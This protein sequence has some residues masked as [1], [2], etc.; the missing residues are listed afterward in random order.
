MGVI[1]VRK[2]LRTILWVAASLAVLAALG[3][4]G[5]YQAWR[6]EP[7]FYTKAL[8]A[9]PQEYEKAGDELEKN[10]LEL[11]N[12]VRREGRWEVEFSDEQ[13]NGWLAVDLQKNFSDLLPKTIQDPRVA[14]SQSEILIACRF[15]DGK[16]KTI[17]SLGVDVR[18][19]DEPNVVAVRFRRARAG[20]IPL[21]LS[22]VI[23]KITDAAR[24]SDVALRWAQEQGDPVAL[25]EVP[26]THEA[27]DSKELL[28][29]TI[30]LD[31]G[32]VRIAGRSG[33]DVAVRFFAGSSLADHF[34]PSELRPTKLADHAAAD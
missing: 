3:A 4:A 16:A 2:I 15:D 23:D 13:I 33:R 28:L 10:V 19:T 26:V 24:H 21:P 17:L 29:E 1:P 5:L 27:Y 9:S 11:R 25:V 7:E 18:L 14:I 31:D 20:S 12:E 34:P 8:A 6:H 32:L 22:R 30:E